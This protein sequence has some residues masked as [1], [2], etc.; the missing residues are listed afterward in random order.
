MNTVQ[1]IASQQPY[2]TRYDYPELSGHEASAALRQLL[3]SFLRTCL[4]FAEG[5]DEGATPP[6]L[7]VRAPASLGKSTSI[8]DILK[9]NEFADLRVLYLVPT[10]ELADEL[11]GKMKFSG[12]NARVFRGRS[13]LQPGQPRDGLTMCAKADIAETLSAAGYSVART[14]CETPK[15]E[16]SELDDQTDGK[17]TCPFAQSCPYFQQMKSREKGVIVGTY[18]YL[19]TPIESLKELTNVDLVIVDEGFAVEASTNGRRVVLTDLM[20][21]RALPSSAHRYREDLVKKDED[22]R[23]L[24]MGCRILNKALMKARVRHSLPIN[25]MMILCDEVPSWQLHLDEILSAFAEERP[26]LDG[27]SEW[28][29]YFQESEEDLIAKWAADPNY[30]SEGGKSLQERAS[31]FFKGL[32]VIE[33]AGLERQPIHAGMDEAQQR[34]L[35]NTVRFRDALSY[36]A[37]WKRLAKDISLRA[38]GAPNGIKI[39]FDAVCG[40]GQDTR[41]ADIALLYGPKELKYLQVPVL[42]IDAS[43]ND[44]IIN[45]FF[46]MFD[47]IDMRVVM[48]SSVKLVQCADRT[49]S[50]SMYRRSDRRKSEVYELMERLAAWTTPDKMKDRRPLFI[51]YKKLHEE[52][53]LAD[54]LAATVDEGGRTAVISSDGKFHIAH[55]NGVRGI[56]RWKHARA[57]V[58]AA[59]MEPTP[60]AV[61]SQALAVFA[62]VQHEIKTGVE[63][64]ALAPQV[65]AAKNGQ[66]VEIQVSEHPDALV[67]LTLNQIREEEMVQCLARGR[68]IHRPTNEP[69]TIFVLSN[70]PLMSYGYQPDSLFDWSEVMPDAYD[71][72]TWDSANEVIPDRPKDLHDV[73]RGY[74]TSYTALRMMLGS[75]SP[76]LENLFTQ[77]SLTEGPVEDSKCKETVKREL[78]QKTYISFSSSSAPTVA[79]QFRREGCRLKHTATVK[80]G[81]SKTA[82]DVEVKVISS[83]PDAHSIEILHPLARESSNEVKTA[84]R[85]TQS[86]LD[87]IYRELKSKFAPSCSSS[88]RPPMNAFRLRKSIS[89]FGRRQRAA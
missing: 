55:A 86:P 5:H 68:P 9:A 3:H 82:S 7:A 50:M 29:P 36:A 85:A 11:A 60:S 42:M 72:W 51:G 65:L 41:I 23:D 15:A 75:R 57:V 40:K 12:I 83:F 43:A 52:T 22:E 49:G 8:I 27:S 64:W 24:A 20:R 54:G 25:D 74:F 79:V 45:Q 87:K 19:T 17:A 28:N 53:W 31:G 81:D 71:R 33:Y 39:K 78:N 47:Y 26:L 21:P 62:N 63:Q 35:A 48:P 16:V 67:S 44:Q 66:S 58:V 6:R 88:V 70:I 69:L 4:E 30:K 84:D 61:E 14:L 76:T 89:D 1:P 46:E 37:F 38:E 10:L 13:A 80:V 59:R 34:D 32:S 2:G 73:S 56:D 18:A 77:F